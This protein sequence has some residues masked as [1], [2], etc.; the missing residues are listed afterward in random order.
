VAPDCW[1]RICGGKKQPQEVSPEEGEFKASLPLEPIS[2][3]R[4]GLKK[5]G[6]RM[7]VSKCIYTFA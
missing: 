3:I 5:A 6:P 2:I 1:R 4:A 7:G